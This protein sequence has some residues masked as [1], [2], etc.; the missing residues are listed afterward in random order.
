MK[1]FLLPF[2]AIGSMFCEYI[3]FPTV[4]LQMLQLNL[5]QYVTNVAINYLATFILYNDIAIII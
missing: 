4:V 2:I 5:P 1:F 3:I